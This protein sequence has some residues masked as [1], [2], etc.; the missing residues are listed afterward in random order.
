M[1]DQDLLTIEF[2]H[3]KLEYQD[4]IIN[5]ATDELYEIKKVKPPKRRLSENIRTAMEIMNNTS[6]HN[7]IF[8]SL[9]EENSLLWEHKNEIIHQIYILKWKLYFIKQVFTLN[10]EYYIIGCALDDLDRIKEVR[11][12]DTSLP[13]SISTAIQIIIDSSLDIHSSLQDPVYHSSLK[14]DPFLINL[15]EKMRGKISLSKTDLDIQK[16]VFYIQIKGFYERR[17][18]EMY[19]QAPDRERNPIKYIVHILRI[20]VSEILFTYNLVSRLV[21]W[22]ELIAE[23]VEWCDILDDDVRQ[24]LPDKSPKQSIQNLETF[25]TRHTVFLSFHQTTIQNFLLDMCTY[26]DLFE[27]LSQSMNLQQA[28]QKYREL[29]K[30]Q[31]LESIRRFFLEVAT[32]IRETLT[33]FFVDQ[34]D[35]KYDK[36]FRKECC[37]NIA[38]SIECMCGLYDPIESLFKKMTFNMKRHV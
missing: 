26:G 9:L 37:L 3:D 5:C 12:L 21:H 19:I 17:S 11:P 15:R 18:V 33:H 7:T 24:R 1:T 32:F 14:E 38:F 36:K 22:L 10:Y 2:I 28:L 23:V 27:Q 20:Y 4:K 8:Q 6:L 30:S 31:Q 34:D 35:D 16:R 29:Y 25:C 13:E